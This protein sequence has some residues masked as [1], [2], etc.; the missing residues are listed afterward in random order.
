MPVWVWVRLF[1]L[2]YF[3]VFRRQ[4]VAC[5]AVRALK[6]RGRCPGGRGQGRGHRR[7]GQLRCEP[8][9]CGFGPALPENLLLLPSVL[10]RRLGSSVC[11]HQTDTALPHD[12]LSSILPRFLLQP[13]VL[14]N[15]HLRV[16]GGLLVPELGAVTPAGP[17]LPAPGGTGSV[18]SRCQ[19]SPAPGHARS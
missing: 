13:L 17:A 8:R 19:R 11:E 18:G 9:P 15:P 14:V 7:L 3:I 10:F 2:V 6:Q 1:R 4:G 5:K 16:Q 12:L